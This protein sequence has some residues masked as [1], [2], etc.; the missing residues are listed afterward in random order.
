MEN[1]KN[2]A[3][4]YHQKYPAGKIEVN[5]TKP[6]VTA[7]DLSLAYSPGV[8]EPCKE[9]HA[10]PEDVYRY[11]GRGNLVAVITN[12]TAVLGLGNIGPLAAKPVMEG[13]GVLF[14][15]FAE[16]N[17]FD[18]E[19]DAPDPELVIQT[20]K[21]LEP[22][23]GGI[24]LED[25]KAP[26]CFYIEE[27]LREEMNIPVFHDDQHGTAVI[28]AAAF[29]NASSIAGK[30]LAKMKVVFSGGG[31]AAISCAKL[32]LS[33]GV[34]KENVIMCDSKGVIYEG[35]TEGM[36]DYKA[37]FANKTKA[38][39]LAEAMD[40]A[41]AFVGVSVAGAVSQDMVKSMAKNP[42]IFAMANPDPEILPDLVYEVRKDAI[43]ATGRT[44]YPNQV[45]NVLCFPSIFRG[46]LDVQAT[47]VNEEM[48]IA[49]VKALAEL[50]K[51][52]VPDLVSNAYRNSKFNFGRDYLIPKPF[53]PRVI[54]WLAPAIAKA[55]T[56]SGVAKKPLKD[57]EAYKEQ[58][59]RRMGN[60]YMAVMRSIKN[61]V[62]QHIATVERIPRIVF[63][64]GDNEKILAAVDQVVQDRIAQPI[65]L[66]TR[67]VIE[68][69]I[70]SLNLHALDGNV[71]I[72]DPF[73][74]DNLEEYAQHLAKKR[75]RKGLTP[76][77]AL[78]LMRRRNYYGPMMVELG[79]ADGIVNGLTQSYPETIRPML[80]TIGAK[81][82]TPVAGIYVMFLRGRV[83]FFADTTVN[84]MFT[85]E[86][87][88]AVAIETADFAR[89]FLRSEEPKVAMLSY[90]NFGS[91]P[92]TRSNVVK[93]AVKICWEKRPDLII[94][95]EMQLDPAVSPEIA[96]EYFP[97]SK[98]K[99]DANV[100]IFPNLESANIC[101]KMMLRLGGAHALGPILVGMKKPVNI[102]QHASEIDDVVNITALTALEVQSLENPTKEKARWL[103]N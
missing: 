71:E 52:P 8:A 3:L 99:G 57:P 21:A 81:P 87:L 29:L 101:Y 96:N 83:I 85:P 53:D 35:R 64:E 62:R 45:N 70:K 5:P 26:E 12:G 39:T 23:F 69:K 102:L 24:N 54:H 4:V 82:G 32:I 74:A 48:K 51:E 72:L 92:S 14:K 55:A 33:L 89:D 73:Q 13:K 100:L 42:I 41:D 31:A 88:A 22:T 84:P 37:F 43:C 30:K 56:D 36:N 34:K 61:S 50:A 58:L 44:D 98:I 59:E 17:V 95:G 6:C 2:Q 7:H 68:A 77:R 47:T 90:S 25:I 1:E 65:L 93:E 10:N 80:H 16:I 76:S 97:F 91:A 46:A 103:T 79:A 60:D 9:I 18:I 28:T 15:Q 75:E 94:D 11:T 49:A 67:E 66:G 19:L 38:R 78:K 63:P 27:K 86:T 40:G 20:C